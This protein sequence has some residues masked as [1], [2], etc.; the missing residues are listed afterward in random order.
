MAR[1]WVWVLGLMAAVAPAG[2]KDMQVKLPEGASAFWTMPA[3][4]LQK[5]RELVE[6]GSLADA[7]ALLASVPDTGS[8]ELTRA[9]REGREIIRRIRLD[10]GLS[11]DELLQRV[12]K[13][14]PA[15][16]AEDLERWRQ[17]GQVQYRVLD[18]RLGY[19]QREPANLWKLC[20]EA[21]RRLAVAEGRDPDQPGP[22]AAGE[23]KLIEHLHKV[24]S[25]ARR[26]GRAEVEPVRHTIRYALTVRANRPGAHPGAVVRCWLA[27]PQE[28]RQQGD[29]RLLRTSPAGQVIAP[30]SPAGPDDCSHQRTIYFE[31]RMI[32]PSQPVQFVA[33]YEYVSFAYYPALDDSKVRPS[34]RDHLA[35]YLQERPPHIRFTPEIRSVV[36]Q[37]VA[38][39]ANPLGRARRIFQWFGRNIR[40][41]YE[42]EYSTIPSFCE[43]VFRLRRGDCGVQAMLFITMC[44]LAGVPARWQSGWTTFPDNWN[45]HDWAEIHV[46]PWGWLPVD[47]SY[48]VKPSDDPEVGEFYFGHLDSYRLITNLDYGCP[49]T[50]PKQDLRSETADFQ[51]GEVEIDG[52]NL[53]FDEWDYDFGFKVEPPASSR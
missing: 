10:Y 35:I 30:A 42:D 40:Y 49:L 15:V 52:R 12:G 2:A 7:E 21:K 3:G 32:D 6:R 34:D 44:R 23:R 39:E 25:E 20:D 31:Q 28:Y 9:C 37:I 46:P 48:G 22:P 45:M 24:V 16:T 50:P 33:E 53:Y 5:A 13:T 51:R 36:E 4:V 11:L 43:K 38:G 41:A 47:V 17:A 18:G 1:A 26:T 14:L 8:A 29:V 19:W 27:F